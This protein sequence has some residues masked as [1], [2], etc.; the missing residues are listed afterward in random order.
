ME[1]CSLQDNSVDAVLFYDAL[2]HVVDENKVL[3]NCF[4]VLLP[5]GTLGVREDA[6]V[7]GVGEDIYKTDTERYGVVES[8]FAKEYLDYV[9]ESKGFASI[10]RY[11]QINGLFPLY[12]NPVP[13]AI[14]AMENSNTL[15]VIKPHDQSSADPN[16]NVSAGIEILEKHHEGG[17]LRIKA[18]LKNFGKAAW[19]HQPVGNGYITVALR[20]GRPGTPEFKEAPSRILLPSDV[21][22]GQSIILDLKSQIDH[23]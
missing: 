8:P 3:E 9:L 7:A 11:Y 10:T 16:A 12:A 17:M 15:T 23:T 20:Q 21:S 6:W 13:N 22:P 18:R 19:L 5:G 4:R 14:A 2:H 1:E